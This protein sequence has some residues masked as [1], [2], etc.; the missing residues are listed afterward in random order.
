[1]KVVILA[2]CRHVNVLNYALQK[3]IVYFSP[4]EIEIEIEMIVY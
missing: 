2:A 4:H 3:S 1:M